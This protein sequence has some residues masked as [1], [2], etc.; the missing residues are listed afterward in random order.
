MHRVLWLA[1]FVAGTASAQAPGYPAQPVKLVV[2]FAA[3]GPSDLVARAFADQAART[4]GQPVIVENKPGANAVLATEAVAAA[5]PD[6]LTLLAAATNHTMIPALYGERI[7]FDAAKSFV[8]VCTIAS[9]ATVLVVG[10]SM[11]VKNVAEFLARVKAKPDASTYATPGQGSSP[12]LATEQFRRLTGT[13]MVHVPYKGAAPAVTDLIGGQVDLS[14]ATVGS[15]LP[16]LKSG[17]LKA[18][19]VASRQRSALLPEV[20]T[21]EEAGVKGFV[22]D[23]WYGVLAPAGTPAEALRVLSREAAE[24]AR[25]EPARERLASAGL[26]PGGVC[27]EAFAAQIVREIDANTRLARDLNLKVE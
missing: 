10:P 13:S 19:A 23:T 16:H 25:S 6:G 20:P 8:P 18:L 3:G 17:K 27:G 26:E 15:V 4:L 24:F 21:F 14:F 11:P 22:I 7:K 9:S 1:A 5:K 12:H 2:G